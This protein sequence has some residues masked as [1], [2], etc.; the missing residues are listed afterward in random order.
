M[1]YLTVLLRGD[2]LRLASREEAKTQ[3][4]SPR[5][6]LDG[7]CP[8]LT[9]RHLPNMDAGNRA[10]LCLTSSP[11]FTDQVSSMVNITFLAS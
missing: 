3:H 11:F 4:K 6:P 10:I 7:C 2:Q 5:R 9:R 8:A 1:R